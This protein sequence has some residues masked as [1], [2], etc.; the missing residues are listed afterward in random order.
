LFALSD[1]GVDF[2]MEDCRQWVRSKLQE[3]GCKPFE[4]VRT[5][6]CYDPSKASDN[7]ASAGMSLFP[8]Q[9]LHCKICLA[10]SLVTNIHEVF[11]LISSSG[12]SKQLL[13]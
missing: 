9:C 11:G 5:V 8:L 6:P 2:E 1:R 3:R 10:C 13:I 7:G 4:F 12:Y